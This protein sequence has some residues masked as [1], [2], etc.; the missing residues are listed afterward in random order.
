MHALACIRLGNSGDR[1]NPL[2][3]FADPKGIR[4]TT[5]TDGAMSILRSKAE[6]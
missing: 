5:S 3:I 6:V 4:S 2:I 1:S